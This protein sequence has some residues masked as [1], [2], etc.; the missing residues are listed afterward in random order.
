MFI[1]QCKCYKKPVGPRDVREFEDVLY[2][3]FVKLSDPPLS[4][5]I[6]GSHL[7]LMISSSW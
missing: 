3:K 2:R 4:F 7:G 6:K 1:G 5:P